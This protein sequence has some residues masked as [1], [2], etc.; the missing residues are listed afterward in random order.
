M[1][2]GLV[3]GYFRVYGFKWDVHNEL[4]FEVPTAEASTHAEWIAKQMT[5]A[6]KLNVPLKVDVAIGPNWLSG[7]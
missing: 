1:I 4:V 5:S 6:I 3:R 7:K 2:W